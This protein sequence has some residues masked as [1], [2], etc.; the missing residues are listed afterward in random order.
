M[1]EKTHIQLAHTYTFY[2]DK[3]WVNIELQGGIWTWDYSNTAMTWHNQD[4]A[5]GWG[6]ACVYADR[7]TDHTWYIAEC[8]D[9]TAATALIVCELRGE[10]IVTSH[11]AI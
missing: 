10:I 9:Q 4:P 11:Y 8:D 5:S 2:S 1:P 6:G 7:S 3:Y